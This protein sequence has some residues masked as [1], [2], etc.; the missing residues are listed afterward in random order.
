LLRKLGIEP[1]EGKVFAWAAGVLFL[2]GWT[3]VSVKNASEV[4]FIK[5]VGVASLPLAF[6]ANSVLLV[7]STIFV[8]LFAARSDR[9]KL[10]PRVLV[11]LAVSLLPLW[12]LVLDGY[13]GAVWMLVLASKQLESIGLLVFW[14][15]M[16]DLLHGR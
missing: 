16:G 14:M 4:L 11:I 6:L 1:G 8:G 13:E 12:I 15:A 2:L 7:I 10:L 5:T 9:L 3:E